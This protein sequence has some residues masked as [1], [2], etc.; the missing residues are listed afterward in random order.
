M[1]HV[2]DEDGPADVPSPIPEE[3]L[4]LSLSDSS[5]LRDISNS[6]SKS[7]ERAL[8]SSSDSLSFFWISAEN[9]S[10]VRRLFEEKYFACGY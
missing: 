4:R 10:D 6:F 2:P 9:S 5:F 8:L 3:L 7:V 1:S